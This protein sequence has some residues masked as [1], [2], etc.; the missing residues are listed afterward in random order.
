MGWAKYEEDNF[1]ALTDRWTAGNYFWVPAMPESY[2]Q[3]EKTKELSMVKA[4][5][6]KEETK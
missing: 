5:R 3:I 1:E 2:P 6:D 4:N